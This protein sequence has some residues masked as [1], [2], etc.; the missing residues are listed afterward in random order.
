MISKKYYVKIAKILSKHKPY[1]IKLINDFVSLFYADN[2]KFNKSLF[3]KAIYNLN[4]K[5]IW[6]EYYWL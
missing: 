6:L 2:N 4:N 1:N 3:I 5:K